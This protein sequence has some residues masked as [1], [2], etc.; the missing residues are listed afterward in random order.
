M[1][2]RRVRGYAQ[3]FESLGRIAQQVAQYLGPRAADER[4]S[5]A[6]PKKPEK[7]TRS[8]ERAA[9][10]EVRGALRASLLLVG[11]RRKNRE[12]GCAF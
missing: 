10:Q 2:L 7:D 5:S 4:S 6:S 11:D 8:G 9:A 1:K 3:Q 12:S